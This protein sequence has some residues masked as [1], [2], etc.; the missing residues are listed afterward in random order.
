MHATTALVT[1]ATRGVGRQVALALAARDHV[2]LVVHGR[3]PNRLARLQVEIEE[4]SGLSPVVMRADL[5]ELAQARRLAGGVVARFDHLDVVVH[6]AAAKP[7]ASDG[8]FEAS[9]AVNHLARF[10]IDHLLLERLRGG[11]GARVVSVLPTAPG[12]LDVEAIGDP[13]R[14]GGLAQ[15]ARA[16]AL[17][18]EEFARRLG[19]DSGVQVNALVLPPRDPDEDPDVAAATAAAAA[20]RLATDPPTSGAVWQGG[21]RWLGER[22]APDVARRLYEASAMLTEVEPLPAPG[23]KG[24]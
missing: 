20:I 2:R 3:D 19:P 14:P 22:M 16:A 18:V 21:S 15:S 7:G 1:G 4:I 10:S 9:M 11:D 6:C 13:E 24:R 8:P 17:A 12:T 23:A 5:R